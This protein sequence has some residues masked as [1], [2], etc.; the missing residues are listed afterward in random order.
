[1]LKYDRIRILTDAAPHPVGHDLVMVTISFFQRVAK[2]KHL[3][4]R[5]RCARPIKRNDGHPF[6]YNR[7]VTAFCFKILTAGLIHTETGKARSLQVPLSL[8]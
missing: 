2:L 7:T 8:Q 6:E 3:A 5:G 4:G 1:M